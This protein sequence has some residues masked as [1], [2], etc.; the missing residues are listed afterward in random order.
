MR[1]YKVAT[2]IKS[3]VLLDDVLVGKVTIRPN[4][5]SGKVSQS[6]FPKKVFFFKL[7]FPCKAPEWYKCEVG[8][9][10]PDP[11]LKIK[12]AVRMDKP[13]NMKHCG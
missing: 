7:F 8:K 5:M 6:I 12:V 1:L 10:S 13:M 9:R 2:G 3:M 11:D 4:P